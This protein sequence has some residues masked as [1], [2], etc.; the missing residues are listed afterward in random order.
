MDAH[1]NTAVP[2][3][4]LL[5]TD[6]HARLI[7]VPHLDEATVALVMRDLLVGGVPGR[8]KSGLLNLPAAEAA[9]GE[10][11]RPAWSVHDPKNDLTVGGGGD[12]D[13]GG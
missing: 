6:G 8:G 2:G 5:V 4:G 3:A 13:A 9:L 12:A 1:D 7:Q 10:A 11:G